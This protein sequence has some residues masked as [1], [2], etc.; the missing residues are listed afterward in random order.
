MEREG[1]KKHTHQGEFKL[2]W[3]IIKHMY[4]YTQ[5]NLPDQGKESL[6]VKAE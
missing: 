2:E 5:Q 4:M 3:N 6:Q 1:E